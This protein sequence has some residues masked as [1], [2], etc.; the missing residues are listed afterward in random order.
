VIVGWVGRAIVIIT[1]VGQAG[2]VAGHVLRLTGTFPPRTITYVGW[3]LRVVVEI[4][5]DVKHHSIPLALLQALHTAPTCQAPTPQGDRR[6][7]AIR[8]LPAVAFFE[9]VKPIVLGNRTHMLTVFLSFYCAQKST[10]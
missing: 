7:F 10:N 6:D 9:M 8:E 4:L 3:P 1:L 5:S 2:L